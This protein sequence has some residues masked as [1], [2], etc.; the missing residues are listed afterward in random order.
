[1]PTFVNMWKMETTKQ[2]FTIEFE[3]PVMDAKVTAEE[4]REIV[5]IGLKCFGWDI[6]VKA[7]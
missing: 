2:K 5:V 1:M 6:K 7:E 3:Y 4:L